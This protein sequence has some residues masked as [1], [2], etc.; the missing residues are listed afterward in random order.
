MS[1]DAQTQMP[2]RDLQGNP[3]PYKQEEQLRRGGNGLKRENAASILYPLAKANAQPTQ[4]RGPN[5]RRGVPV[6]Q[7]RSRVKASVPPPS[8]AGS[9][10]SAGR[11]PLAS[12]SDEP[13]VRPHI[14]QQEDAHHAAPITQHVQPVLAHVPI[15]HPLAERAA[16]PCCAEGGGLVA[17]LAQAGG[18]L[19]CAHKPHLPA[20]PSGHGGH[21]EP[22][23]KAVQANG[24]Q[25]HVQHGEVLEPVQ[26]GGLPSHGIRHG[27]MRS[28][29]QH[30]GMPSSV[31]HSGLPSPM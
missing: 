17:K 23:G 31:Q 19:S 25:S 20:A 27:G 21:A 24:R 29:A 13:D 15:P 16:C 22:S 12:N 7:G 28:L 5:A 18:S 14:D 26:R 8:A 30:G 11:K 2:K 4:R 6:A 1:L 9:L 10:G 3:L